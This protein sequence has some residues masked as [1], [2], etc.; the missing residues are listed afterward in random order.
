MTEQTT[1]LAPIRYPLT[2]ESARTLAAAGRVAH[3]NTPA[4]LRV[5]HV[6]LFQTNDNTQSED[7]TRAI[8]S[9]LDDVDASVHTQ[10]GFLLEEVILEEAEDINAD[11]VMIGKSQQPVWRRF[12]NRILRDDPAVGSF[13]RERTTDDVEIVEVDT[14]SQRHLSSQEPWHSRELY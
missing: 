4:E 8:S 2:D 9:T 3:D 12:L 13:L 6:N 14:A 10:R 11:I 5:L 1:I 7:L